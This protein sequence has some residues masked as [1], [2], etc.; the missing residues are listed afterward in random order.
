M[1][2]QRF[3]GKQYKNRAQNLDAAIFPKRF[4]GLEAIA[5]NCYKQESCC[6]H[7]KQTFEGDCDAHSD[8]AGN[9]SEGQKEEKPAEFFHLLTPFY[10]SE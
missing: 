2:V 10:V 6:G 8:H 9:G 3:F 1:E 5:H 4:L 7:P